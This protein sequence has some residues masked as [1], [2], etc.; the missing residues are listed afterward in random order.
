MIVEKADNCLFSLLKKSKEWR[1]FDPNL[2]LYL[3]YHLISP[4]LNYG[5]EMCENRQW[6]EIERYISFYVNLC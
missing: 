1:R 3:F 2:I 5:C 4:V 6:E